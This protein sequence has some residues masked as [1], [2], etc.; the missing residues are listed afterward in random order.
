[1][2]LNGSLWCSCA[3]GGLRI[4]VVDD[5]PAQLESIRRG[6]FLYGYQMLALDNGEAALELLRGE[7]GR[8]IDLL[9][10][11]LTLPGAS[12]YEVIGEARRLRPELPILA[13][14]GLSNTPEIDAIRKRG[15]PVLQ[16]PFSPDQ[17][18]QAV[19]ALVG[20]GRRDS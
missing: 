1:M 18:A 7:L 4:C 5:E 2:A 3:T 17:L 19:R 10:T 8:T 13:I 20:P 12:G 11:D 9:V 15:I 16:K 6:L 14:T